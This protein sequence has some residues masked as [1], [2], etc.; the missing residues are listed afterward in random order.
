[1]TKKI[2]D[3]ILV[4]LK[5]TPNNDIQIQQ[6]YTIIDEIFG[7]MHNYLY[8]YA[9]DK[10]ADR[11]SGANNANYRILNPYNYVID[12]VINQPDNNNYLYYKINEDGS[13]NRYQ[14]Q[15]VYEDAEFNELACVFD[16]AGYIINTYY[17]AIS[18]INYYIYYIIYSY[19]KIC[20]ISQ[21]F[22][23]LNISDFYSRLY[24]LGSNNELLINKSHDNIILQMICAGVIGRFIEIIHILDDNPIYITVN[25]ETSDDLEALDEDAYTDYVYFINNTSFIKIYD[26]MINFIDTTDE[27]DMNIMINKFQQLMKRY[28]KHIAM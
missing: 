15:D 6:L 7:E 8:N 19:C 24:I 27:I 2:F 9:P 25:P 16:S 17:G 20:Q 4:L 22:G 26:G 1:M 10:Y 13:I 12:T 28:E 23:G 11:D 3:R 21:P 5:Q 14:G 18:N